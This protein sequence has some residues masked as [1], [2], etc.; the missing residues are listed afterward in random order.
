VSPGEEGGLRV[1]GRD[2]SPFRALT[3]ALVRSAP[4]PGGQIVSLLGVHNYL[5]YVTV[6]LQ[7]RAA[8]RIIIAA[9]KL[10]R[11]LQALSGGGVSCRRAEFDFLADAERLPGTQHEG[12]LV[13]AGSEDGTEAVVYLGISAAAVD[14][15]ARAEARSD[16]VLVGRLFGYPTCCTEA[17]VSRGGARAD[18]TWWSVPSTG[19]HARELNPVAPHLFGLDPLF[20]F[21]CSVACEPSRR[22]WA[23]RVRF[24]ESITPTAGYLPGMGAGVAFYGE[25]P[26]IAL[27]T[28]YRRVGRRTYEL[29]EVVCRHPDRTPWNEWCGRPLT[30]ELLDG[31]RFAVGGRK[32]GTEEQVAAVFC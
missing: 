12:H 30:V 32:F 17:F 29:D 11:A 21:P 26:D 18:R 3:A 19:P 31:H 9:D 24:L 2:A 6:A 5:V 15:A 7:E 4:D 22:Q 23:H 8:G 20:H 25:A 13:P 10:D 16:D 27:A 1:R 14:G 28:S